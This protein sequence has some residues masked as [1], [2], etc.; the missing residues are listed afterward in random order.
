[1]DRGW[2]TRRFA[3]ISCPLPNEQV[4]AEAEIFRGGADQDTERPRL[5]NPLHGSV[6]HAELFGADCEADLFRPA[7]SE[8]NAGEPGKLNVRT[9]HARY[10]VPYVELND[11][12]ARA[13][14]GIRDGTTCRRGSIGIDRRTDDEARVL[15]GRVAQP[16]AEREQRLACEIEVVVAAASWLV[17]IYERQL[18]LG[19]RKRD[20]QAPAGV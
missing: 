11:F 5:D 15:E 20:W 1:M 7:G 19:H 10:Q 18:T 14:P 4:A 3:Q 6:E 17:V 2:E 13:R 12:V 16:E 9:R 8:M